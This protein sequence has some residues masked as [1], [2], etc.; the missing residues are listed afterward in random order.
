MAFGRKGTEHPSKSGIIISEKTNPSG[1]TSW[2]VEISARRTGGS[3]EQKQFATLASAKEHAER[4]WEEILAVGQAAFL[5]TGE[6]RFDAVNALR[7][8][9]PTGLT[10]VQAAEI[11]LFQRFGNTAIMLLW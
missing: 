7:A 3:R 9:E 5:L 10:L 2:R 1:G 6:Q 11:L 4:R 8:L